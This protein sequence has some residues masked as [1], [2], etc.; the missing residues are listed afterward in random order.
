MRTIHAFCRG[1][2]ADHPLEARIHPDLVIDA[3][4]HLVEEVV[5]ETVEDA[6]RDG[7]GD[8]GD[9]HL[10]ALAI[11]GFGPPEIVE[12]LTALLQAGLPAA[13]LNE[14]PFRPEALAE[15]RRR[16]AAA[17]GAVHG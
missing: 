4:G 2:L 6:L 13:V 10:L 7:Y 17:C 12:A 5:R 16:L 3:D 9:P 11:R 14:D 15:F 1:L 8:P